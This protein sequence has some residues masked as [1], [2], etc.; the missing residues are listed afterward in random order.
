MRSGPYNDDF[1]IRAGCVFDPAFFIACDCRHL[2]AKVY[3][4]RNNVNV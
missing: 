2:L 3:Q 4:V 1:V